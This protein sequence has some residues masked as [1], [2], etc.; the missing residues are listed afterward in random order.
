[1]FS[2]FQAKMQGFMHFYCEKTTCDHKLGPRGLI[3]N[4]PMH[5]AEDVKHK[6]GLKVSSGGSTPNLPSTRI[7]CLLHIQSVH[8]NCFTVD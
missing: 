7:L 5:G 6:E 3:V 8:R 4:R 2:N 1:M